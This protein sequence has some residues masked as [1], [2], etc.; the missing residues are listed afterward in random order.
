M[1]DVKLFTYDTPKTP[2]TVGPRRIKFLAFPVDE[3][4]KW[5]EDKPAITIISDGSRDTLSMSCTIEKSIMGQPNASTLTILNLSEETRNLFQQGVKAILY[6][7]DPYSKS[8]Q[9]IFSGAIFTCISERSGTEIQTKIYML[10]NIVQL[11][12]SSTTV[13]YA[14]TTLDVILEKIKPNLSVTKIKMMGFESPRKVVRFCYMGNPFDMLNKLAFQ[15]AFSWSIDGSELKIIADNKFSG[16]LVKITPDTGLI[17]AVPILSGPFYAQNG[18]KVTAYPNPVIQC[19]DRIK[20][21][22][23]INSKAVNREDLRVA[24]MTF[25]LSTVSNQWDMDITCFTCNPAIY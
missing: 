23:K 4:I 20:V 2:A 16:G 17:N 10:S 6:I 5:P 22:S 14:N 11:M 15:E 13:A 7:A 12:C 21:E 19:G 8:Y 24:N 25:N 18:V 9:E 3:K 1:D